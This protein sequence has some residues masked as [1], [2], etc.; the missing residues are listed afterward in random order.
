VSSD[1]SDN[2]DKYSLRPFFLQFY[3]EATE[4]AYRDYILERTILFCRISWG[5]VI[6]LGGSFAFLDRRIFGEASDTVLL[7]R[8]AVIMLAAV[9]LVSSFVPRL[10]RLLVWSS[11]LFII[12]IG[13]FCTVLIA[14]SDRTSFTPYFTGLFFAFVGIFTTAGVGFKKS[15]LAMLANLFFFEIVVGVLAPVTTELLV[16]YNFFLPGIIL[17]F[18]YAGYLIERVA[19]DNYVFS[20]RLLDSLSQVKM[21]SGLLPICSACKKIRDDKGYWSQ[22]ESYIRSHSEADFSH[23]LCPGCADELYPEISSDI[24]DE[25]TTEKG[26]SH[27]E[28]EH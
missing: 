7:L 24:I 16:V 15:L 17:V 9:V 20:A 28:K 13:G 19:R 25:G 3:D 22:I 5:L 14:L 26:G 4:A 12:A 11:S 10:R 2:S 27:D 1:N 8:L 21:L 18:A 23:G 6:F